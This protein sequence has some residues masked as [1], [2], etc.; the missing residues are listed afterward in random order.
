MCIC[1]H[2]YVYCVHYLLVHYECVQCSLL[3]HYLH[4]HLDVSQVLYGTVECSG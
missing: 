3:V 4:A 2:Y 1:V